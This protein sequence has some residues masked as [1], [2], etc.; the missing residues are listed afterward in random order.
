[1]FEA[2]GERHW[3]AY[4]GK[5]RDTLGAGGRAGL[6]PTLLGR[7]NGQLRHGEQPVQHQ[8]EQDG[9]DGDEEHGAFAGRR[10]RS[11]GRAA[12]LGAPAVWTPGGGVAQ[13]WSRQA[14]QRPRASSVTAR[15][16]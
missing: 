9:D 4:F 11:R 13:A 2:V 1:M 15:T 5:I 14:G 8:Q 16:A 6:Q 12:I 3:P 10:D 7:D